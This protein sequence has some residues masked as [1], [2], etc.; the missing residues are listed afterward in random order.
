MDINQKT[1]EWQESCN[2]ARLRCGWIGCQKRTRNPG[3]GMTPIYYNRKRQ[4]NL[5]FYHSPY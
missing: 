2:Q 3:M 1:K 5:L 4:D